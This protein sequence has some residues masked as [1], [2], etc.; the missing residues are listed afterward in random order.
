MGGV[1]GAEVEE[2]GGG[3][4]DGVDGGS[5][6]DVAYVDRGGWVGGEFE[7]G[8]GGEGS[9]EDE[10]GVGGAGV[11]PGV[12]SGAGDGDAKAQA[13]E[14]PGDDGGGSAAFE[15]DGGGDAPAVG[16]SLEEVT[17]APEVAFAFFAYVGGEEDGDGWGDVRVT[18]GGGDSK[19]CGETGGVVADA[20][21]VDAR[22]VF[23]FDGV[24]IGSGGEDGVEV[25]RDEDAGSRG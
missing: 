18:E 23:E 6:G 2:G 5:A 21:G 1:G 22:G 19:E 12:A 8:D 10:D 4:G 14:G 24:A 15:G 11:G 16:A 3:L 9:A 20:G 7:V 25:G 17:H 13:A